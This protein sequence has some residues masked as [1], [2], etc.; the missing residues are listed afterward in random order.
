M[1][2]INLVD[3]IESGDI[4]QVTNL[5]N[6]GININQIYYDDESGRTPLLIASDFNQL[7]ICKIL[8]ENGANPNLCAENNPTP[9]MI[10]G[11]YGYIDIVKELLIYGAELNTNF[12][13]NDAIFHSTC[14]YDIDNYNHKDDK[15]DEEKESLLEKR[16]EIM[17]EYAI[18]DLICCKVCKKK[19]SELKTEEK[20]DTLC[21]CEKCYR[22]VYCGKEC[23]RN[24]WK[25]HKKECVKL[26]E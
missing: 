8:L 3:A 10:A 26:I 6:E 15:T 7:E 16:V 9:L 17:K 23:Q 24:D 12:L 21:V 19:H 20:E 25:E 22:S 11:Y 13:T 2:L 5:I 14:I 4:D 18:R 1:S